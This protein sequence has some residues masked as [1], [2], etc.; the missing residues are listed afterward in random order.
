MAGL[1]TPYS[2]PG[3]SKGNIDVQFVPRS[4]AV[5]N[6]GSTWLHFPEVTGASGWIPPRQFGVM[7]GAPR[8]ST[9]A[10]HV[11][12]T[13]VPSSAYT[14]DTSDLTSASITVLEDEYPYSPGQSML[15][16]LP[17]SAIN[18][19]LNQFNG[20]SLKGSP[21]PNG[22]RWSVQVGTSF[23][24]LAIGTYT[25]DIPLWLPFS[26]V[27]QQTGLT[28]SGVATAGTGALGY[29]GRAVLYC[30]AGSGA[31]TVTFGIQDHDNTNLIGTGASTGNILATTALAANTTA[32][33]RVAPGIAVLA[34]ATANDLIGL[35]PRIQIVIGTNTQ[36][37]IFVLDL[38]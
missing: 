34:N 9:G 21:L 11:D 23:V 4:I 38:L 20:V 35:S 24:P 32:V 30:L 10:V 33:L 17:A 19:N 18:Q 16:F 36:F 1:Q 12:S 14:T 7:I 15:S 2:L 29:S 6:L 3:N 37:A 31:G 28:G 26:S 8:A 25:I 22:V 13:A 27:Q 5:D